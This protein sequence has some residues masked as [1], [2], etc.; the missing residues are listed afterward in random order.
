MSFTPSDTGLLSRPAKFPSNADMQLKEKLNYE[1]ISNMEMNLSS[2]KPA[3]FSYH[4][5]VLT[6]ERLYFCLFPVYFES[7][8]MST[9]KR[10][11]DV[12][13]GFDQTSFCGF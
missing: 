10:L 4:I 13:L 8:I 12:P 11:E 5:R 2:N 7:G 6:C 9:W 1:T 3:C